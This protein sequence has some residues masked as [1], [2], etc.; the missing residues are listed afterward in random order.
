M[1]T[2][3]VAVEDTLAGSVFNEVWLGIVQPRARHAEGTVRWVKI[4]AQEMLLFRAELK[5]A[6]ERTRDQK[7]PRVAGAWCK[8]CPALAYCDEARNG[9]EKAAETTF[10]KLPPPSSKEVGVTY[11]PDPTRFTA[12]QLARALDWEDSIDSWFSAVRARALFELQQD[13]NSVPGYKIVKKKTNRTWGENEVEVKNIFALQ[14][15]KIYAPRKLLSP[16]QME[17]LVGK[18]EVARWAV[19][20]QG[21]PTV[22]KANDKRPALTIQGRA[23]EVFDALALPTSTAVPLEKP[24]RKS[25]FEAAPADIFGDLVDPVPAEKEPI[26]PI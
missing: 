11:L 13:P 6:V 2:Y 24:Q 8:F 14:G 20:P 9:I 15:D 3:A 1:L 18:E 19:K 7:A 26:W 25:G 16:A 17:K 10:T 21:E 23:E 12:D 5:A 4:P 22:V